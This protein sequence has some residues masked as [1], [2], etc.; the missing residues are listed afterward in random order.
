MK[1]KHIITVAALAIITALALMFGKQQ[2]AKLTGK[3]AEATKESGE[4]A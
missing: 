4:S 2:L 3:I 1:I